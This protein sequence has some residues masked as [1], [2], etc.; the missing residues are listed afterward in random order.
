M[1]SLSV[2]GGDL[3][4]KS[5]R[6]ENIAGQFEHLTIADRFA[7]RIAVQDPVLVYIIQQRSHR[8]AAGVVDS[9]THVTHGDD[10]RAEFFKETC[11]IAGDVAESLNHCR[12]VPQIDTDVVR[13]FLDQI[14]KASTGGFLAT[15]RSTQHDGLAGHNGGNGV[16][17]LLAVSIHHPGHRSFVCS[18]IGGRDVLV[19]P[20][21]ID[22]L[23]RVSSGES[24]QLVAGKFGRVDANAPL[25]AAV[26][27]LHESALP[28]HPHGQRRHFAQIDVLV[29]TNAT[30]GRSHGEQML[31]A[32]AKHRFNL[33][34]VVTPKRIRYDKRSLGEQ[35]TLPQ[36]VVQAHDLS[37]FEELLLGKMQH[38]RIPLLVLRLAAL[39]GISQ[40]AG[41]L[42]TVHVA[43]DQV[44]LRAFLH[45]FCSQR[46]IVEA[47]EDDD[48]GFARQVAYAEE[49]VD[50]FAVRQ[51][52]VQKNGV[53]FFLGEML[54]AHLYA[55]SNHHVEVGASHLF[56]VA[57]NQ[58]RLHRVVFY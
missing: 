49:R 6:R 27:K 47:G 52:Q 11:G 48:R 31:D 10:P 28:R 53:K 3:V 34:I 18:Q 51:H 22:D 25:G 40:A 24:L 33:L 54:G 23:G 37:R 58:V 8:Q 2:F 21:H 26:G 39:N 32:V 38:R 19:G 9:G 35:Q 46:N 20:D 57:L 55:I 41:N 5:R 13:G 17:D 42:F 15:Q 14:D 43:L 29:I 50:A 4:L 56:Q 1:Q 12:C 36:V 30:F 45:C 16:S 7:V 44:R